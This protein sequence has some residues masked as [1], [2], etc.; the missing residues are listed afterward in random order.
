MR[1]ERMFALWSTDELSAHSE[2]EQEMKSPGQT[3]PE[4]HHHCCSTSSA[5]KI[6]IQGPMDFTL[7]PFHAKG[8]KDR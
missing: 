5:F 8:V 7:F 6:A 1:R 4:R 2:V 3:V